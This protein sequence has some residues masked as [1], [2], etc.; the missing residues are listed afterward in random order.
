MENVRNEMKQL[1]NILPLKMII[2]NITDQISVFFLQEEK[3]PSRS[4]IGRI[5]DVSHPFLVFGKIEWGCIKRQY[6]NICFY[7]IFHVRNILKSRIHKTKIILP[8]ER[9]NQFVK[10]R[11]DAFR[12][13][14]DRLVAFLEWHT[15]FLNVR[16]YIVQTLHRKLNFA[17][18][19][20]TVDFQLRSFCFFEN[21]QLDL[22]DLK[23]S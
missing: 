18:F 21:K 5:T 17:T 6:R 13:F 16:E 2:G 9:C 15:T 4:A 7:I 8:K 19:A 10:I 14:N 22:L 23:L 20:Q 1:A 3:I 12:E 11:I